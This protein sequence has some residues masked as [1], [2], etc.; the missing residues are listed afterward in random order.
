MCWASP[1]LAICP[2][3][4]W[5]VIF[6]SR[7][8]TLSD[9]RRSGRWRGQVALGRWASPRLKSRCSC[10]MCDRTKGCG[11]NLWTDL[12]ESLSFFFFFLD[13]LMWEES[14][15]MIRDVGGVK[16]IPTSGGGAALS[17]NP[18]RPSSCL[19]LLQNVIFRN[20]SVSWGFFLL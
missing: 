16:V 7:F 15:C 3:D 9:E 13:R 10:F 4:S 11:A 12:S 8:P 18:P 14:V 5:W 19:L 2:N 20:D 1:T 17:L 6:L